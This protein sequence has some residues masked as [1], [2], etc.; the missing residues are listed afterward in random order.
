MLSGNVINK[1]DAFPPETLAI[2]QAVTRGVKSEERTRIKQKNNKVIKQNLSFL[3]E[4][5]HRNFIAE[6]I[7]KF[8]IEPL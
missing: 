2:T 8:F 3:S 7:P 5:F 1:I 4:I 6:N